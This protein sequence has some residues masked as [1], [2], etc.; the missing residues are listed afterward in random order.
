MPPEKKSRQLYFVNDYINKN[1]N[2]TGN[3]Q[4]ID[5]F[6][7]KTVFYL[8]TEYRCQPMLSRF[9]QS[10]HAT[11][12]RCWML[13]QNAYIDHDIAAVHL[14]VEPWE[15]FS[16][17]E[18]TLIAT[19]GLRCK[20]SDQILRPLFPFEDGTFFARHGSHTTRDGTR[21]TEELAQYLYL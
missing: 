2:N 21:K 3:L 6:F 15:Y 18:R 12:M 4:Q 8:F 9:L 7:I 20:R 14:T 17:V 19:G 1:F 10:F 13:I 11:Q 5:T 16:H